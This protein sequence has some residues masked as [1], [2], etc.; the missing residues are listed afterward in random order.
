MMQDTAINFDS[1][2]TVRAT[3]NNL[4]HALNVTVQNAEQLVDKLGLFSAIDSVIH[5]VA[6][7]PAA[8]VNVQVE[9]EVNTDVSN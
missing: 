5:K 2:S 4:G 8:S 1:K 6:T 7:F 3:K 9:A